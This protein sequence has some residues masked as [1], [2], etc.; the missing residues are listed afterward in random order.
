[1]LN[2]I[3]VWGYI[4]SFSCFHWQ[5]R[6]QSPLRRIK[7]KPFK[8]WKYWITIFFANL[9][10]LIHL[11]KFSHLCCDSSP[12]SFS[13]WFRML[14]PFSVAFALLTPPRSV[15]QV[16]FL[17]RTSGGYWWLPHRP[18]PSPVLCQ[19]FNEIYLFFGLHNRNYINNMNKMNWM[20]KKKYMWLAW[21]WSGGSWWWRWKEKKKKTCKQL[22]TIK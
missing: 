10:T 16:Q 6:H 14:F 9:L 11:F 20:L 1:M 13:V 2:P 4:T 17:L 19:F 22:K 5:S 3:S 12:N 18:S 8:N 15:F 7:H 21:R